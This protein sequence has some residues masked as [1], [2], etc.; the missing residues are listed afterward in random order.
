[1]PEDAI[2]PRSTWFVQDNSAADPPAALNV[3]RE[4]GVITLTDRNTTIGYCRYDP[5]G[6]IEYLFVHPAHRRR[7]HALQM[8]RLVEAECGCRL[9]FQPPISPL[10]QRLI[11][12]YNRRVPAATAS[13]DQSG[14]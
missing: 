5:A 6:E 10:G 7:G 13:A 14:L 9:R 12:V 4:A 1:M 2:N 8:L 3:F 11:D